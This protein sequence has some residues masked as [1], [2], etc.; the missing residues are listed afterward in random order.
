MCEIPAYRQ[1][2]STET[3][4]TIVHN[5]IVR[6]T[7]A[8]LVS[9]LVLLDLSAAF[10]TVDHSVLLDVLTER[11]GV[12]K[13]E[14][15]WF[16]SYHTGRTQTFKTPSGSS[17]PVTLTCSVPQGSVIGPKEFIIYTEDID[18]T[19]D[20][21]IINHHLYADDSNCLLTCKSWQPWSIGGE[22]R[23][24]SRASGAGVRRGGC[25]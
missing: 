7:D 9:V 5:D 14:L 22:W 6:A 23:N 18:E 25:S 19:I 16:R 20:R 4:V 11:F 3:A 10:D 2:H 21:F 17:G 1:H 24:A 12:E 13:R 15:E 8:G